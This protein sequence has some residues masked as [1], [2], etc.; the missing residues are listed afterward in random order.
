M[1]KIKGTPITTPKKC[2]VGVYDVSSAAARNAAGDTVIDRVAVKRKIDM[3]WGP[4]TNA[5]I[6]TLLSAVADQYFDVEYPDPVTGAARTIVCYVSE[7]NAPVYKYSGT[8]PT[9]ESLKLTLIER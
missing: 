8:T 4:L 1:I 9:W 2:S 5:Q 6:S 7:R 3:E